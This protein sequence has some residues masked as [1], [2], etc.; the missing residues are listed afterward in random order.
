M[1]GKD[2]IHKILWSSMIYVVVGVPCVGS[3][4]YDVRPA[5]GGTHKT[6]NRASLLPARP[7]A[8]DVD[9]YAQEDSLP[10]DDA[11]LCGARNSHS[12]EF[13]GQRGHR[14][15][16]ANTEQASHLVVVISWIT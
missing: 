14:R 12:C 16:S 9:D 11:I 8:T 3:H 4:G 1:D 13:A 10:N 15:S 5:T 7:P 2:P 6:L